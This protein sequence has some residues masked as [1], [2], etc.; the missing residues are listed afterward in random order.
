MSKPIAFIIGAGKNIG[1]STDRLLRSKGYRVA[2][3]ARSLDVN[4]ASEDSLR[5]KVDLASA[6]SI[7]HAFEEIR[8][9]WGEPNVVIYNGAALHFA[10]PEVFSVSVDDFVSDLTVNTV[11]VYAAAAEAVKGFKKL[12]DTLPKVFTVTG[13]MLNEAPL[14]DGSFVTLGAGKSATAHILATATVGY[15]SA[16]YR[17]YY[18]DQRTVE[19]GP[20]LNGVDGE[21]HAQMFESLIDGKEDLPWQVTFVSG[22]GYK[23][24]P[25]KE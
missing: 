17:F 19:G 20:V 8:S 6:D 24:F 9:K 5:L 7:K 25:R 13:N 3:A 11:S 12:P 23:K 14:G 4:D 2:Q 18:V 10:K 15:K 16:G 22:T 1:A 21:G